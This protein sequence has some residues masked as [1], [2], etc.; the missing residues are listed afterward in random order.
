MPRSHSLPHF[1]DSDSTFLVSDPPRSSS[2]SLSPAIMLLLNGDTIPHLFI[3]IIRY[4]L[5]SENHTIKKLLLFYL[6]IIYKTNSKGKVLSEM[7]L[8]YQNLRNNLWFLCR[9]NEFEIIEPLIP[10]ILANL[11]HR[12]PFVQRNAVLAIM[13]ILVATEGDV[14]GQ[15]TGRE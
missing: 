13:F 14:A 11:E 2:T 12:H 10:S 3:T 4:V 7:N 6:E 1:S 15:R 8:I 9:L 5:L